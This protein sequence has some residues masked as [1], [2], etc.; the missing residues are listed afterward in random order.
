VRA[1]LTDKLGELNDYSKALLALVLKKDGRPTK[2]VL[3][4]LA[5][6]RSDR[7]HGLFEGGTKGGWMTPVEVSGGP[8]RLHRLRLQ[9]RNDSQ[10]W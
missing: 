6:T 5:R 9:A 7:G 3:E 2:D 8:P 1:R 4:S 10:A